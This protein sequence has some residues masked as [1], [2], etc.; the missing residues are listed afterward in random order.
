M[1]RG[2][3]PAALSWAPFKSTSKPP[4]VRRP[5]MSDCTGGEG[6]NRILSVS[7]YLI[8]QYLGPQGRVLTT[9]LCGKR[10]TYVILPGLTVNR[11]AASSPMCLEPMG[12]R[13]CREVYRLEALT[14]CCKH[15]G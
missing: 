10:E 11:P 9:K 6:F 12:I 2:R 5:T 13:G 15:P 3:K 8:A 14:D 1:I 4:N 7:T